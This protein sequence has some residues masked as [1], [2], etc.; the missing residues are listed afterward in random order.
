MY[1]RFRNKHI[2]LQPTMIVA[3]QY[4]AM[5]Q[6][7]HALPVFAA[8]RGIPPACTPPLAHVCLWPFEKVSFPVKHCTYLVCKDPLR[9]IWSSPSS[10]WGR[11]ECTQK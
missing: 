9:C 11:A 8:L 10:L 4:F 6:I 5:T 7:M 3:S 2:K 1:I